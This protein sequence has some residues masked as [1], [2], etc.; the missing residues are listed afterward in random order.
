MLSVT[1][2]DALGNF[3]RWRESRWQKHPE[4]AELKLRWRALSVKHLLH[5]LPGE[6]VLE[7]GAGS[8]LWTRQLQAVFKGENPITSAVFSPDLLARAQ[9]RDLRNSS[10]VLV[11]SLE[12]EIPSESF[13]YVIGSSVLWNN[14]LPETLAMIHR[15]LKPGGVLLFFEPNLAHPKRRILAPLSRLESRTVRSFSSSYRHILHLCSHR[16]FTHVELAPYDLIPDRFANP[17][18]RAVQSKVVLFEHA[19]AIRA[20][21]GSMY[22]LARKPGMRD[23]PAPDLA[24]HPAL[25]GSVSFVIPCHNEA[26]NIAA[27]VDRIRALYGSYVHEIVL[28]ND[29]STDSTAEVAGALARSDGRVKVINRA[30]P[31]G[32]G[33]ALSDGYQA[34]SGRYILSMDCDFIDVLPEF[35]GLFDA[36][37]RGRDGAIGSRF[38]HE[39]VIV[40]YPFG[41]MLCNRACHALIKVFLLPRVRDITNNLKLYRSGIFK[42]LNI[43]SG[44]FSANLETGLKPLLAGYD[45]EEVPISWINRTLEMGSSSFSVK[46]VGLDYAR[47]LF[48]IWRRQRV[49]RPRPPEPLAGPSAAS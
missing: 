38:S 3:E 13:D 10:F 24:E 42:E 30:R 2:E 34:A 40:N 31:N 43:E 16:G 45:I 26:P 29:N 37:A 47:T 25:H 12:T 22:I 39:S 35:R 18:A 33:R 5:I 14:M 11:R 48:R 41:K 17:I 7:L 1:M 23:R 9:G 28:V 19:P 32:V 46:K 20:L 27:L 21:C 4:A 15:A 6:T 49:S 8:G 44:H 36:V